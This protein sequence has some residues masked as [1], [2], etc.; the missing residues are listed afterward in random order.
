MTWKIYTFSVLLL[1]MMLLAFSASAAPSVSFPEA[2]LAGQDLTGTVS[3]EGSSNV[4]I[5]I[6]CMNEVL[7]L[8]YYGGENITIEEKNFPSAGTYE[9]QIWPQ[10]MEK[11][12]ENVTVCHVEVTGERLPGPVLNTSLYTA[13]AGSWYLFEAVLAGAEEYRYTYSDEEGYEESRSSCSASGDETTAIYLWPGYYH[14]MKLSVSGRIGDR[15]TAYTTVTIPVVYHGDL[16]EL[17]IDVQ[18]E[19]VLGRDVHVTVAGCQAESY[20]FS[21][22]RKNENSE[23][24]YVDS[25]TSESSSFTIPENE[26]TEAGEYILYCTAS[27][28]GW[29]DSYNQAAFSVNGQRPEAPQVTCEAEKLVGGFAF[30]FSFSAPG[31]TGFRYILASSNGDLSYV[32]SSDGAAQAEIRMPQGVSEDTLDV[33]AEIGGIWSENASYVLD[34]SE[35]FGSLPAPVIHVPDTL[36]IGQDFKGWIETVDGKRVSYMIYKVDTTAKEWVWDGDYFPEKGEVVLADED[37]FMEP[38]IYQLECNVYEYGWEVGQAVKNIEVTG[39]RPDAPMITFADQVTYVGDPV[40]ATLT[41][42]GATAFEYDFSGYNRIVEADNECLVDVYADREVFYTD[43]AFSARAKIDGVWSNWATQKVNIQSLGEIAAPV[44]T[45]ERDFVWGEDLT[46]TFSEVPYASYYAI[47]LRNYLDYS[48]WGYWG[49]ITTAVEDDANSTVT[50]PFD[51]YQSGMPG[52]WEIIVEAYSDKYETSQTGTLEFTLE[53]EAT[54]ENTEPEVK[55]SPEMLYPG[56]QVTITVSHPKATAFEITLRGENPVTVPAENGTAVYQ[57]TVQYGDDEVN[58]WVLQEGKRLFEHTFWLDIGYKERIT[59]P[60]IDLPVTISAGEKVSFVIPEIQD[61]SGYDFRLFYLDRIHVY[62]VTNAAPG[63]FEMDYV[64]T[65][66]GKYY[67]YFRPLIK[68]AQI[69]GGVTSFTVIQPTYSDFGTADMILPENLLAIREEAFLGTDAQ[70]V[71]VPDGCK[72]IGAR[73]FA[74][75]SLKAVSLPASVVSLGE[76]AFPAHVW[77]YAPR[78]STVYTLARQAGYIVIPSD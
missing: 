64:F 9:L 46:F 63:P 10:Q 51:K 6:S 42:N 60:C 14:T 18:E 74:D 40:H 48:E 43:C 69:S 13:Y 20:S 57:T 78:G 44:I 68:D 23:E 25:F 65:K 29:R 1:S 11:T 12:E 55:Y 35:Y 54:E 75:S 24:I 2:I 45:P 77:V 61:A 70:K 58:L 27:S 32:Q 67:L 31:A 26:F 5:E 37:A 19:Y 33:W 36:P 49:R 39:N 71:L 16:P 3:W 21:L 73:A 4:C 52:R 53:G 59:V 8:Q 47:E 34:I 56:D 28:Y 76:N 22:Y 72:E 66:P 62:T 17:Q 30:P 7:S 50:I 41:A 15:Y 38:G